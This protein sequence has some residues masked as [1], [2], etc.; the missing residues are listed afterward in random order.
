LTALGGPIHLSRS[1][2]NVVHNQMKAICLAGLSPLVAVTDETA[3]QE[4]VENGQSVIGI[5][6]RRPVLTRK[7]EAIRRFFLGVI[8]VMEIGA[9]DVCRDK[10]VSPNQLREQVL[11]PVQV[12]RHIQPNE[13]KWTADCGQRTDR[14]GYAS[15]GGVV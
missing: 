14:A 3:T 2:T 10:H 7:P 11:A 4:D 12:V 5:A 1:H 9:H 6:T 15:V 8:A 13:V